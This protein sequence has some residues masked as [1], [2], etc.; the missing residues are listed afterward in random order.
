[1]TH[2]PVRMLIMLESGARAGARGPAGSMQ[3]ASIL[4][5]LVVHVDDRQG[6]LFVVLLAGILVQP[7]A[8]I[9]RGARQ[10]LLTRKP[11]A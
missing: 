4:R 1:M 7:R 11:H 8:T 9:W 2:A 5:A 10:G 6:I 3:H